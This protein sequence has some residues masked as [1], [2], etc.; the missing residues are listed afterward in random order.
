[1]YVR[2]SAI[3]YLRTP[4]VR[5]VGRVT[6][7]CVAST[8]GMQQRKVAVIGAGF[9]GISAARTLLEETDGEVS[10]VVLEASP[11]VGGRA[12]TVLVSRMHSCSPPTICF[13]PLDL[14]K[15]TM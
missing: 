4:L 14:T 6:A 10:V 1:M 7:R 8:S 13:M 9:A 15:D 2:Q 12:H 3:Q 11:R 5:Q